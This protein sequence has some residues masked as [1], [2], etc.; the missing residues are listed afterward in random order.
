MKNIGIDGT[1]FIDNT[2]RKFFLRGVNLG[3]STKIPVVPDGAT[4]RKEGFFDHQT[5]SFVG[6]PFPLEEADE[7]FIRLRGWGLIFCVF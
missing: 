3:G 1:Y 6:R 2:L 5:V 4:Y 7:H